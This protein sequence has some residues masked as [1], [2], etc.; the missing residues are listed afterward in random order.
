MSAVSTVT[1][2]LRTGSLQMSRGLNIDA[3]FQTVHTFRR[4]RARRS[5][6]IRCEEITCFS[7]LL[8]VSIEKVQCT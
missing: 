7:R 5:F 6:L 2:V 4:G 8:Q 1:V 3:G